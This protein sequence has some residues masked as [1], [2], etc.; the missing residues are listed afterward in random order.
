MQ[1]SAI[2]P[3]YNRAQ[4]L[5][6]AIDSVLQQ[7]SPVDEIILV[8]D[9]STDDSLALVKNRFPQVITVQQPN[10]QDSR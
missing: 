4:T 8:D 1:I 3:S 10:R 5:E 2:I 7:T 6:R 9:G